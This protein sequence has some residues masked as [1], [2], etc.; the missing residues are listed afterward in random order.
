MTI[1]QPKRRTD[2]MKPN[3]L[4]GVLATCFVL[5]AQATVTPLTPGSN[6]FVDAA[7]GL[8]WSQPDAFAKS[9]YAT[10]LAT[11]SAAT[12]EGFSEWVIPTRQQFNWL[13]QTQGT[14]PTGNPNSNY[15]EIMVEAPFSG[16]NENWYWTSDVYDSNENFAFSPVNANTQTYL[17]TTKV[18]VWAVQQYTPAV[19]EP[20]SVLL[21]GMGLIG[22]LAATRRRAQG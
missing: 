20:A 8:L 2:L 15:D 3:R 6:V 5:S 22:V 4:V 12:I 14:V 9:T 18:G 1:N 11:V 7:H 17:H 10:A 13:Y 19:P 21:V 16:M